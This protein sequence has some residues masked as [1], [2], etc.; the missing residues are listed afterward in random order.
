ML[1]Q[2]VEL[3]LDLLLSPQTTDQIDMRLHRRMQVLLIA[4][5]QER[6]D[7]GLESIGFLSIVLVMMLGLLELGRLNPNFA[8]RPANCVIACR[9]R[10]GKFAMRLS[11][12]K[13]CGLLH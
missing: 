12:N 5:S 10:S 11:F 3:I 9:E 8:R 1:D 2:L 13:A 7:L 4:V 6:I